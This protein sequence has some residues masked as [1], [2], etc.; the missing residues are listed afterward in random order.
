MALPVSLVRCCYVVRNRIYRESSP[1]YG[2]LKSDLLRNNA[3]YRG[4]WFPRGL[5]P[6]NFLSPSPVPTNPALPLPNTPSLLHP[7]STQGIPPHAPEQTARTLRL[8]LLQ[9]YDRSRFWNDLNDRRLCLLCDA[10]FEG[11]AIRISVRQ[12]K[13]VFKCPQTHCQAGLAH[14]VHPGNP[15]LNED[16]WE[17]WMRPLPT[18]PCHPQSHT[19]GEAHYTS[20]DSNYTSGEARYQIHRPAATGAASELRAPASF[21]GNAGTVDPPGLAD[22]SDDSGFAGA[23]GLADELG[24]SVASGIQ[25]CKR[26]S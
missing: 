7:S 10:E 9:E 3:A 15:L 16:T 8:R 6:M 14:F 19:S 22:G 2:A 26:L 4:V 20:G 12:G 1:A 18:H 5:P 13:P 11:S 24:P 23:L 25:A 21:N 17:D